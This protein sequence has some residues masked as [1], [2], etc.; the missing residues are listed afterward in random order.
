MNTQ[1][2]HDNWCKG[3]KNVLTEQ[4]KG[5]IA[6][7][8][9]T[10]EELKVTLEN[11]LKTYNYSPINMDGFLYAKGT[12]VPVLLVA[13]MD[14]TPTV[15]TETGYQNRVRV[16]DFYELEQD[17]EH[18]ITS[19]Q[20]IGGDDRC[21]VYTIL[22]ILRETDY[23]P[24]I[25]FVEDE[26][27]GCV[28]SQKFCAT[29]FLVDDIPDLNFM[30]QIDRRGSHDLVFYEDENWD[31]HKWCEK[32]TGWKEAWG[33]CSDISYL[34]PDSG[35]AAVNIS[36]GYYDEHTVFESVVLEELRG[37]IEAVKK[38]LACGSEKKFHY[39]E[40]KVYS[41]NGLAYEYEDSSWRQG[42]LYV[43]YSTN[44]TEKEAFEQGETEAE[45][46]GN[47]FMEHPDVCFNDIL[48]HDFY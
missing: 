23:R 13:H 48:D 40:G 38:L 19:P 44:G 20:G 17:G 42:E 47:F 41:W 46:F 9:L 45:A 5:F 7:A 28:G 18:I 29:D 3:K 1:L 21:G 43:V 8:K 2:N 22:Q 35:V 30:V 14:T 10:Q 27:I 37:S 34:A 15:I 31:F 11:I 36:S 26:E 25:L 39:V 6:L 12:N 33:T 24:S 4:N 16:Q 32:V